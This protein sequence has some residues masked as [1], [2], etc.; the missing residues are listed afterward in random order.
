MLSLKL[1]N[2]PFVR[3]PY[4]ENFGFNS[5]VKRKD[6]SN[7]PNIVPYP[8]KKIKKKKEKK[9]KHANHIIP[10]GKIEILKK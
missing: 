10:R 9:R 3:I 1:K 7:L 8:E 6:I 4:Y 2:V 5:N